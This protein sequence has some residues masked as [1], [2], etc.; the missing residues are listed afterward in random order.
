MIIVVDFSEVFS[1]LGSLLQSGSLASN[2]IRVR[3]TNFSRFWMCRRQLSN[4]F[5]LS[6]WPA[7]ARDRWR[8]T[9]IIIIIII[10]N[11]NN[12][13]V[14]ATRIDRYL[15]PY[16]SKSSVTRVPTVRLLKLYLFNF[17]A[18][19]THIFVCML[20]KYGFDVNMYLCS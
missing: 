17:L 8:H 10:I 9:T 2:T 13:I 16:E 18:Y 5:V 11:D 7:W 6:S 3:F 15:S 4:V 1:V 20:V 12:I 14:I 19:E